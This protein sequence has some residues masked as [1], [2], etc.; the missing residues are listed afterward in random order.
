MAKFIQ[1]PTNKNVGSQGHWR[2]NIEHIIWYDGQWIY[3]THH[4]RIQQTVS[5]DELDHLIK[6]AESGVQSLIPPVS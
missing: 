6:V 4:G 5:S 3:L 2:I 1:I